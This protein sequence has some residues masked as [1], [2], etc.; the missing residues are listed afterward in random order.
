MLFNFLAE[1]THESQFQKTSR[2][3]N[4]AAAMAMF[5]ATSQAIPIIHS[6]HLTGPAEN[7]PNE[8]AGIGD[9]VVSFDPTA[10]LL[11]VIVTFSGL[12]AG[13][14]VAHIHCCV[15]APGTA[16]VATTT[17]TFPD[18][19]AGVLAGNYSVTLD[20]LDA[21]TWN[22]AFIAAH[23][24]TPAGAEA[25]FAAGYIAGQS[26]L[27]I[28]TSDFPLGEIRGFLAP[29]PEPQSWALFLGGLVLMGLIA[30]RRRAV[31]A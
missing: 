21:G 12:G 17:P 7:P 18:F 19:S 30:R 2:H 22:P 11:G 31:A 5:A 20:T 13:T 28:H 6:A 4:S 24:G 8:S 3:D 26:Y 25:F 15:D 14:T 29:V 23:G 16:G 9:T 27:N 10:H 1:G